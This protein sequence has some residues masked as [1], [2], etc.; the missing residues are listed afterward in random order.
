M[1]FTCTQKPKELCDSLCWGDLESNQQY[2]WSMPVNF[3]PIHIPSPKWL[4]F[5]ISWGWILSTFIWKDISPSFPKTIFCWVKKWRE[6]L[7]DPVVK[8]LC[9]H[10]QGP[11]FNP[12][13]G[14]YDPTKWVPPPKKKKKKNWKWQV[15]FFFQHFI[16]YF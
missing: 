11:G 4:F 8:T 3:W 14:N 1:T 10:C 9:S 7:G 5:H 12:W 15:F 6:F 16:F 2:L 13:S